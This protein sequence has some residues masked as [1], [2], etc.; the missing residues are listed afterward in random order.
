MDNTKV[1]SRNFIEVII[2]ED[3]SRG[4]DRVKTRFPPEPNGY[5]HIGHAKAVFL[6]YGLAQKYGGSFYLR[7]DDTN[8]EKEEED[9][10]QSIIKDVAWLGAEWDGPPRYASDYFDFFYDC[11]LKLIDKGLAYVDDSSPE[12]LRAMRGTLTEGGTNSPYRDRSIEENRELFVK[13]KEGAFPEGSRILRAKID[14]SSPNLNM[15][16]PALYRI[17]HASHHNTGDAWH[18]YPMYD[19][20]HPL[21][22]AYEGITHS[23]CT[24]E[25]EDHRPLYDW[26]IDSLMDVMDFPSR[27]RQYEFARLEIENTVTSKRRLKQLVD[28]GLVDGWDDPRLP[29]LSGLRRRG[30]TARALKNFT[31]AIGVAK[32]NSTVEEA[33]L[34]Y[35]LRDDLNQWAPRRMV[36]LRP[37]KV[38]I[39]NYPE[40][41]IEWVEG[42]ENPNKP[43]MGT[44][45]IP[46]GREIYIEKDDFVLE[47]N[48]KYKRLKPGQD[49]RLRGAYIVSY[50]D[51]VTDPETGEIVEVL[52][53]YDPDTKSGG[54]NPEG[55]KAKGT[56]HWVEAHHAVDAKAHLYDRLIDP[57]KLASGE[58]DILDHF[59][60]NSLQVLDGVKAEYAL[61]DVDPEATYQFMRK[62]YFHL[63]PKYS[64]AD[65]PVFN[66]TIGLRDGYRA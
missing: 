66:E 11:A 16:D 36:V 63:D 62:G 3:L 56:I 55:R 60:E 38:T 54:P 32:N 29:T 10:V 13:M 27:P 24:L 48:K 61:K 44:Y 2:D 59:N 9:Y 41:Q 40:G 33:N 5:L 37:L 31:D 1:E 52:V 57:E 22:D 6:N 23:I 50:E 34:A 14:M 46:F 26:V 4:L 30:Y 15:R 65:K 17:L 18:I 49:V 8:P 25:F 53:T 21:E 47:A 20:A 39:T 43:E 19:F 42:V 58:G 12:E 35:H 45:S 51:H 7:F 28:A 64:T